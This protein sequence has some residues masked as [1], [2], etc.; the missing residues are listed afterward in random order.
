MQVSYRL[1]DRKNSARILAG[2]E[3]QSDLLYSVWQGISRPVVLIETYTFK[4]LRDGQWC[5]KC[6]KLA[7]VIKL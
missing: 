3:T 2:S 1:S 7:R 4:R 6:R 5:V